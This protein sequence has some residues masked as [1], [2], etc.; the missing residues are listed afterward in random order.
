MPP[1]IEDLYLQFQPLEPLEA[2]DPRYV[3]C[4][5]VRGVGALFSQL[6]LPLSSQKPNPLFFAGHLGD[7]KTTI[8]NQLEA[9]LGTEGLFVAYGEA[10]I[11]DLSA[12]RQAAAGIH[13]EAV[14]AVGETHRLDALPAETQQ[15]LLAGRLVYE[16][17][18][19][20]QYWYD[21]SPLLR[22]SRP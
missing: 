6:S 2:G 8:L 11:S 14:T 4:F 21:P 15:A 1:S 10:A 5:E 13:R 12:L 7:G 17:Y 16:Y 20:G 22:S 3:E 18:L 19:D 9:Q